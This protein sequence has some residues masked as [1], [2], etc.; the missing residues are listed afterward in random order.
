MRG[1]AA[2]ELSG[3]RL[4]RAAQ[5]SVLA[6]LNVFGAWPGKGSDRRISAG[7]KN[8]PIPGPTATK[9]NSAGAAI[10]LARIKTIIEI[11]KL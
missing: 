8:A 4:L 2:A 10:N 5:A 6:C 9:T 7:E 11:I 3:R 1:G